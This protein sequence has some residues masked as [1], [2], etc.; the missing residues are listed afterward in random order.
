M[1]A[2]E[3]ANSLTELVVIDDKE[4]FICLEPTINERGEPVVNSKL[5]RNCGCT[6]YV[7]PVCWNEWMKGKSDWDCPICHK[8]SLKTAHILPNPVLQLHIRVDT[9]TL[10]L[11]RMVLSFFIFVSLFVGIGF[12]ISSMSK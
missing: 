11:C 7:H 9:P 1:K 4:C 6:F 12:I 10:P 3:S 5:L 8:N 2:S